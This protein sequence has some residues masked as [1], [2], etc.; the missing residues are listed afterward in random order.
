MYVFPLLF[1]C[2]VSEKPYQGSVIKD[3][4]LQSYVGIRELVLLV[5]FFWGG[6]GGLRTIS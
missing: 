6:G 2:F 4:V 5:F 3:I 1:H